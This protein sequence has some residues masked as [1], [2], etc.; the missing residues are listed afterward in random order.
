[1]HIRI[2]L[3]SEQ[4]EGTLEEDDQTEG[5]GLFSGQLKDQPCLCLMLSTSSKGSTCPLR[6]G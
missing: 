1:M 4:E 6:E 2:Y 3:Q 5:L